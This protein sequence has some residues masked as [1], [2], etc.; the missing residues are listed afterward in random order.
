MTQKPAPVVFF[1]DQGARP[2]EPADAPEIMD[3]GGFHSRIP[4]D[5]PQVKPTN[6]IRW[7][8]ALAMLLVSIFIGTALWDFTRALLSKSAL[9]GW[10][11][12]ALLGLFI[13]LVLI[14]V[15][16][17]LRG[18]FRLNSFE[19]LKS[20]V[21]EAY[22]LADT[23]AMRAAVVKISQLYA[24]AAN[25]RWSLARFEQDI[26]DQFEAEALVI[27][28]EKTLMHEL[29]AQAVF[30]IEQ[31]ARRVALVTAL[32]PMALA[33]M[34]STLYINLKMIRRIAEIYGIRGGT[35]GS[36]KL[37]RKVTTHLITSGAIAVGEDWLS[38]VLGGGVFSKLSRRF[39]EGLINAALSARI[40]QAA[41]EICRPV[42]FV[43]EPKPATS[44]LVK[45]AIKG[46]FSAPQDDDIA[47]K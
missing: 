46:L 24:S 16:K 36:W 20:E 26:H 17:E 14:G 39:G 9:L 43:A 33:D 45:N 44:K 10:G 15:F 42:P 11:F 40:G 21:T 8:L 47:A 2:P 34:V 12:S 23:E 22:D 30:E 19:K 37:L 1:L 6:W 31:A 28:T 5:A 18:Y 27:L 41:I 3:H 13:A 4:Q 7:G 25:H 35:L 38:A 32:V 29:D